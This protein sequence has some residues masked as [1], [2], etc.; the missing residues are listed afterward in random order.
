MID[1]GLHLTVD[2]AGMGLYAGILLVL[3]LLA[4]DDLLFLQWMLV[5]MRV[6]VLLAFLKAVIVV[7]DKVALHIAALRAD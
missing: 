4:M 2:A 5:V 1:Q 7:P 6:A 3:V